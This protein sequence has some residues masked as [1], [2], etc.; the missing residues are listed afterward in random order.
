MKQILK[1]LIMPLILFLVV[2]CYIN[3]KFSLTDYMDA[4]ASYLFEYLYKNKII[5]YNNGYYLGLLICFFAIFLF[6]LAFVLYK[7]INYKLSKEKIFLYSFY[8]CLF[9]CLGF[10]LLGLYLQFWI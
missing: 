10:F 5:D 7:V 3:I 8:F 2:I 6:L 9:I 1:F 4:F